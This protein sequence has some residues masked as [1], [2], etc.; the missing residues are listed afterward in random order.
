MLVIEYLNRLLKNIKKTEG[1]KFHP[2]CE[3]PQVVQLGFADDLLLFC[4]G[5][6]K[7]VK[8][9]LEYF[10][11]FFLASGLVANL[12]KSSI[13]FGVVSQDIQQQIVYVLGFV[14]GELPIRYLGVPLGTKRLSSVQCQPLL[15]K[16]L[17]RVNLW[18]AKVLSYTG[19]VQLL[20]SVLFSLQVFWAQI[21]ILPKKV[22]LVI[23]R[24][25][26]RFLWTGGDIDFQ[27]NFTGMGQTM[28][29]FVWWWS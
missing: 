1:F 29:T 21:F 10:Q 3:K 2:K 16:M 17:Q 14:K 24:I 22:V 18:I 11:K 23:E 8:A 7:S 20:K 26:K 9:V 15:E 25:C 6:L 12:N 13:Y 4:R 5:D 19:R 28:F 27:K